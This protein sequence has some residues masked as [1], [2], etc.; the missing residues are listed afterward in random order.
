MQRPNTKKIENIKDIYELRDQT[1][2]SS[3][4]M[5]HQT[6]QSLQMMRQNAI[7]SKQQHHLTH[8]PSS[9]Q[10]SPPTSKPRQFTIPSSSNF[11]PPPSSP[12]PQFPPSSYQ[13][14]NVSPSSQQHQQQFSPQ[15]VTP[16]NL[17]C[18]T[19]AEHIVDCPICGRLYRNYTPIYSIM[20]IVL[21]IVIIVLL[22][23]FLRPVS[24]T[25]TTISSIP[26]I[27]L[28]H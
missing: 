25:T 15:D 23:K 8:P 11:T 4:Q 27:T 1:P 3:S 20:I 19:I 17:H 13:F 22:I 5:M 12:K 6:P 2:Q 7:Q 28:P 18:I 21:V 16:R 24:K 26:P 10:F 9:T 14:M